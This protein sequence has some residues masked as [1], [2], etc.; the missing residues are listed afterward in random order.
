MCILTIYFELLC[1]KRNAPNSFCE[2]NPHSQTKNY[3]KN[4]KKILLKCFN[5]KPGYLIWVL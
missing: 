2:I 3:D 4:P 5:I 1:S